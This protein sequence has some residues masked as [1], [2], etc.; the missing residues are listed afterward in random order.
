[1]KKCRF[2]D[3]AHYISLSSCVRIP[4][5]TLDM[6]DVSTKTIAAPPLEACSSHATAKNLSR[7]TAITCQT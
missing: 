5:P 1:V 7:G 6:N 3:Y 2:L 4:R